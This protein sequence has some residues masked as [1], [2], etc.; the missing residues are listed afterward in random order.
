MLER[1]LAGN[2]AANDGPSV[3]VEAANIM[4]KRG[5]KPNPD[6]DGFVFT[7]DLRHMNK[8]LYGFPI[9]R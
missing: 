6:G 3:T 9:S 2:A 4:L 1:L 5:V 8:G 7:R